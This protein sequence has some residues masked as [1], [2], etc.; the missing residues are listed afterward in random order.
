M[1]R[2]RG[3][4][5]QQINYYIDRVVTGVSFEP[6]H[7]NESIM[8]TKENTTSDILTEL[9]QGDKACLFNLIVYYTRT[10]TNSVFKRGRQDDHFSQFPCRIIFIQGNVDA[11]NDVLKVK[12]HRRKKQLST[13]LHV[14]KL[15]SKPRERRSAKS[16]FCF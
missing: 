2:G 5:K 10:S 1:H 3:D 13:A 14:I 12:V 9:R 4:L 15:K 16:I 6:D 8:G 11:K 7:L